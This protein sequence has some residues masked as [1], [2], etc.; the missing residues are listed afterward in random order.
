MG[1]CVIT[2]LWPAFTRKPLLH[3]QSHGWESAVY[4]L[5]TLEQCNTLGSLNF[6]FLIFT[7]R[8]KLA[9]GFDFS[10]GRENNRQK[11]KKQY[12]LYYKIVGSR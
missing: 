3:S 9:H 11:N 5:V 1:I 12:R 10:P 2:L 7:I 6:H 8:Y 4:K